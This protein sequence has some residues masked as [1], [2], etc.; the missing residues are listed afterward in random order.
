MDQQ[1]RLENK[2]CKTTIFKVIQLRKDILVIQD[3]NTTI[4]TTMISVR[5]S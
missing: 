2:K 3:P 1:N 4:Q 5:K